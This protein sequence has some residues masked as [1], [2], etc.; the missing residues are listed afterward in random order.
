MAQ[1]CESKYRPDTKIIITEKVDGSNV[2]IYNDNGEIIALS[3]GGY[4]CSGS[5]YEQHKLFYDLVEKL[6][7]K[8]RI[9]ED[10]LPVG[11]RVVFE[12][13]TVKH[14][15]FYK[16]APDYLL[17]DWQTKKGRKLW[18]EYDSFL[19]IEKVKTIYSGII[20]IPVEHINSCIP[21]KGFYGAKEGYEGLVY[22]IER[23]NKFDFLSKWVRHD[24][25][26][27]KYQR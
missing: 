8:G 19:F 12:S 1:Y 2:S 13:L 26:S 7:D 23:N 4:K 25:Q 17:I 11:D 21:K 14:G 6:K 18:N 20:P 22:R 16:N 3:R 15:A 24:Y 10:L 5:Q 9:T 27:L